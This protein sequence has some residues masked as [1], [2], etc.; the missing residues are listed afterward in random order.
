MRLTIFSASAYEQP[1]FESLKP[2]GFYLTWIKEAL[3]L[4]S[5]HLASGSDAVILFVND[6]GSAA[7]L[8]GLKRLGVKCIALRCAGH[9]R[10]DVSHAKFIG[11]PIYYVP[12]YPPYAT[13]EHAVA[14]MMAL[15]RNLIAAHERVSHYDF[16]LSG[17]T[18]FNFH[19]KTVGI[20]GVGAI[21]QACARIMYGFGCKV[22][23]F[24]PYPYMALEAEGILT[25]L[26]FLEVLEKSDIISLHCPLSKETHHLIAGKTIAH[27]KKGTMLINAGRGGLIHTQDAL[28]AVKSGQIGWLGLDVYENE[29]G[30][31]FYD[32]SHAQSI[33]DPLLDQLLTHP[34]ILLTSHQGF[35]TVEALT[36]IIETTYQSLKAF[37]NGVPAANQLV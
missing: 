3:D 15:S 11:L 33:N 14:L 35:L 28:D 16:S 10:V 26:P 12:K 1:L 25:Y 4:S 34:R 17:L 36:N 24:D 20:I 32:H 31:F 8:D 6:D 29:K 2:A 18:G 37:T 21:G 19:G 27:F 23:A 9:D 5:L 13:A 30:I 7:V 22:I